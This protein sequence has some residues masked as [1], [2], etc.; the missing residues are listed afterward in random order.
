MK[1]DV[2]FDSLNIFADMQF[3]QLKSRDVLFEFHLKS[4]HTASIGIPVRSL[5]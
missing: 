5:L 3:Y 4:W 1:A 2:I